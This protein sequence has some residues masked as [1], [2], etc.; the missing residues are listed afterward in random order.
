MKMKGDFLIEP[1]SFL[2]WLSELPEEQRKLLNDICKA[3]DEE[4]IFDQNTLN[5]LVNMIR[6]LFDEYAN[7]L[8]N[9]IKHSGLLGHFK[10][11]PP[12][13]QT[14]LKTLRNFKLV[15]N[16]TKIKKEENP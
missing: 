16:N 3:N 8:Y 12:E 11:M 6:F 7:W 14:K 1:E 5:D 2:E 15:V 9:F 10:P 4:E 13:P